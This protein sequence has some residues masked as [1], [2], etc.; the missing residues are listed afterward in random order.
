MRAELRA[1]PGQR[2]R[3]APRPWRATSRAHL[4][5][6]APSGGDAGMARAG[7]DGAA[8]PKEPRAQARLQRAAP[9]APSAPAEPRRPQRAPP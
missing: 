2:R 5:A 3:R 4:E 7:G 8:V 6:A 1:A 9:P